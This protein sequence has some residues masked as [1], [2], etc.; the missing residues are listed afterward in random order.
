MVDKLVKLIECF[1]IMSSIFGLMLANAVRLQ[2][3]KLL[4]TV[5]IVS[6]SVARKKEPFTLSNLKTGFIALAT[7]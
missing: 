4:I 1:S 5:S 7:N 6:G 3:N 2:V